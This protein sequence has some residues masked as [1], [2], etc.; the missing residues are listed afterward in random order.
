[1]TYHNID[2]S[3]AIACLSALPV[4]I[5]IKE[6]KSAVPTIQNDFSRLHTVALIGEEIADLC[7]EESLL[8]LFQSLQTNAKWWSLLTKLG[9]NIDLKLFQHSDETVREN[10]ITSLIPEILRRNGYQMNFLFDYCQSFDLKPQ[11]ASMA[12]VELILLDPEISFASSAPSHS[13][14]SY[15]S[16]GH[17][18]INKLKLITNGVNETVLRKHLVKILLKL[19]PLDYEKIFYL[20][21]WLLEIF[22]TNSDE[23]N[24]E[25]TSGSGIG[26]GNKGPSHNLKNNVIYED[27]EYYEENSVL[28]S[29][30]MMTGG[31]NSAKKSNTLLSLIIQE[32]NY[33]LILDLI[34]LLNSIHLT[35]S[36]IAKIRRA[37]EI[38]I[39]YEKFSSNSATQS[40]VNGSLS[41]IFNY[42]FPFWILLT[43]PYLV[44]EP[45]LDEMISSF[46]EK[47]NIFLLLLN[48]NIEEFTVRSIFELYCSSLLQPQFLPQQQQHEISTSDGKTSSPKV[49]ELITSA[50]NEKLSSKNYLSQIK[51]WELI[52]EKEMKDSA[53]ASAMDTL[54]SSSSSYHKSYAIISLE[55]I[56]EILDREASLHYQVYQHAHV[57]IEAEDNAALKSLLDLKQSFE[58]KLKKLRVE[59]IILHLFQCVHYD[60]STTV[61]N[62]WVEGMMKFPKE[63]FKVLLS[64]VIE[65][66]WSLQFQNNNNNSTSGN[67]SSGGNQAI[68]NNTLHLIKYPLNQMI[69]VW[70][71][72]NGIISRL[73][74]LSNYCSLDT[75]NLSQQSAGNSQQ[76]QQFLHQTVIQLMNYY[77]TEMFVSFHTQNSVNNN[78]S[79]ATSSSAL[80]SSLFGGNK[81][82]FESNYSYIS[83][84]AEYRRKEDY[85]LSFSVSILYL[86]NS[87]MNDNRYENISLFSSYF[88]YSSHLFPSV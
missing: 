84:K 41:S 31:A 33:Q 18:W 87:S 4:E 63:V 53:N 52:Y 62:E 38:N 71:Q 68:T 23:N 42:R 69:F 61:L 49:M 76:D 72:S 15:G 65:Y 47:L 43:N 77:L 67:G 59:Y 20:S 3:F 82:I 29:S 86:C 13:S 28:N 83:S 34:N 36:I 81:E 12:Y 30:V 54:S 40:K 50:I 74:Q 79:T 32:N 58:E 24:K 7:E 11:K 22:P 75:T 78:S 9:I 39:F 19:N 6:L 1:L 17:F 16:S 85:F 5:I 44:F 25:N 45:I 8:L 80:S 56:L 46:N 27:E 51:V 35:P 64:L 21:S 37:P 57:E 26:G 10:Y 60:F 66:C 14:H 73:I 88:S 2:T 48:L 55:K 70:F